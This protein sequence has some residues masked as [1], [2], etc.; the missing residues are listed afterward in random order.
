MG[1][2]KTLTMISLILK[3][4]DIDE[5]LDEKENDS[6]VEE[7]DKRSY[8]YAGKTLVVCPA[9]LVQQ[10][11][12]EVNKHV[13]KYI[14]STELYYRKNKETNAKRYKISF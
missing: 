2:G 3:Q 11:K 4:K 14:L 12:S 6:Q 7:I 8:K 5:N 13:K 10:W 1:L 9:S